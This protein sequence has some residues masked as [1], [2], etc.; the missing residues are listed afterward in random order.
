MARSMAQVGQDQR[1]W[2]LVEVLLVV[3]I[4]GMIGALAVAQLRPALA[5]ARVDRALRVLVSDLRTVPARAAAQQWPRRLLW[6][7]QG[8]RVQRTAVGCR[9]GSV[10]K[11]EL[12]EELLWQD[13]RTV[14]LPADV[15]VLALTVAPAGAEEELAAIAFGCFG[16]P[17]LPEGM[18]MRIAVAGPQ[19][20]RWLQL[21][22]RT[23]R[24]T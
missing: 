18:G 7:E 9:P 17:L 8:Y 15:V 13:E 4:A 23:G 20:Q 6:T 21:D 22:G 14:G 16:E 24:V 2:S 12:P 19:L 1:G 11:L 5:W 10:G 3:S